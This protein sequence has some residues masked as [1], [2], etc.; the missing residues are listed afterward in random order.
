MTDDYKLQASLKFGPGGIGMLNVRAGDEEEFERAIT[1]VVGAVAPLAVLTEAI[2][3]EFPAVAAVASAFQ[4][5]QV[6][7]N[8]YSHGPGGSGPVTTGLGQGAAQT[9]QH[10]QML[11]KEGADWK[12]W[13]CPA[14]KTDPSKCK[15]RYVR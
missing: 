8:T 6:V 11:W 5:T 15:A 14:Q 2:N 10:G 7:P 4:G 13:F 12:G 3:T 9:C 1:N